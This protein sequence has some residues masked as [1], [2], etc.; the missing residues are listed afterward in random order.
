M[1]DTIKLDGS[2]TLRV[3]TSSDFLFELLDIKDGVLTQVFQWIVVIR[4]T[5]N[6]RAN[7]SE[8]RDNDH[9]IN[10][11]DQWKSP[12][13]QGDCLH[14]CSVANTDA[15]QSRQATLF[16]C[17]VIVALWATL[18]WYFHQEAPE[19]RLIT[20][21]CQG[22]AH[23]GRPKGAWKIGIDKSGLF[24]E[25][26]ILMDL[27]RTGICA[28]NCSSVCM[29]KKGVS[30]S[31]S[32]GLF[33]SRCMFW[34]IDPRL[35][36]KT[37]QSLAAAPISPT[38]S[39]DSQLR[40]FENRLKGQGSTEEDCICSGADEYLQ[41][42]KWAHNISYNTPLPLQYIQ[43]NGIRHPLRPKP[44]SEGEVF[45]TRYIHNVGQE[46]SF[47]VASRCHNTQRTDCC[48]EIE[49]FEPLDRQNPVQRVS[50][51]KL[52]QKPEEND[53]D[54]LH[55]WMNDSRV[56]HFW[57]TD[58]PRDIQ[59]KFLSAALTDSHSFPIIGLWDN[60]PFGYFEIYWVKEDSLGKLLGGEIGNWDRGLHCLVGEQRFRGP[61]RVRA[62]LSALV[63]YCWIA[64]SRTQSVMLEPRIDN[65]KSVMESLLITM[66]IATDLQHI[67]KI[68]AFQKLEK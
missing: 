29:K 64:E 19:D 61:H 30:E 60:E 15:F 42:S 66:L 62:W 45:Y 38:T 46:L 22:T 16:R 7:L 8:L 56:S 63:H 47:R 1:I 25:R 21:A 27:E 57:G 24:R 12:S 2:K 11:E 58:G 18:Y 20:G 43:S 14:I 26:Y 23:L 17:Q 52:V 50:S 3:I 65:L 31:S 37:L 67:L 49:V 48:S 13:L 9:R 32:T 6:E 51:S 44:P 33:T 34:Q 41:F 36:L 54:M 35:Y 40:C 39:V 10:V 4:K 68:L 55:R 5:S 59:S 28:S 53:V